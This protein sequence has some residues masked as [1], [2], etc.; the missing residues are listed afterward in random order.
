MYSKA[1][2][3]PSAFIHHHKYPVRFQRNGLGAKQVD[4]YGVPAPKTILGMTEG[5][6]PGW[7]VVYRVRLVVGSKN[8]SDGV[9]V[10][11]QPESQVDLLGNAWTAKTRVTLLHF[12]NRFDNFFSGSPGTGLPPASSGRIQQSILPFPQCVVESQQGGWLDDDCC[13]GYPAGSQKQ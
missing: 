1:N 6:Q 4:R 10:Q 12:H 3:S 11:V 8:A 13:S 9:F 2:D 5:G 7:P